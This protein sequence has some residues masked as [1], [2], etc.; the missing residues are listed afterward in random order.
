MAKLAKEKAHLAI[1][2]AELATERA[3]LAAERALL[4]VERANLSMERTK[5]AAERA[6]CAAEEVT[7]KPV[8]S[9]LLCHN[10]DRPQKKATFLEAGKKM[11]PGDSSPPQ[12][13]RTGRESEWYLKANFVLSLHA[14]VTK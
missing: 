1:E 2:R 12:K 5:L 4:A 10:E 3:N 7:R 14:D 11:T 8:R 6:S 13:I 9:A